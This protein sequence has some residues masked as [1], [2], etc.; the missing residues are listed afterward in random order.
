MT[1]FALQQKGLLL[2]TLKREKNFTVR[3]G[4]LQHFFYFDVRPLAGHIAQICCSVKK[5]F[6]H[7]FLDFYVCLHK[8]ITS[9]LQTSLNV[10]VLIQT[11]RKLCASVWIDFRTNFVTHEG[12]RVFF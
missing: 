2:T 4:T 11:W 3:A 6:L 9:N 10:V 7:Q 12:I 5:Q 8:V 1:V